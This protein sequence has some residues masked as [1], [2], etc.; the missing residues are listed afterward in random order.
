MGLDPTNCVLK[1]NWVHLRKSGS[2]Q[3]VGNKPATTCQFAPNSI[4]QTTQM[5]KYNT[6]GIA[7]KVGS[8]FT[9][10]VKNAYSLEQ[11]NIAINCTN[12]KETRWFSITTGIIIVGAKNYE[13]SVGTPD[14]VANCGT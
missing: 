4:Y 12:T 7:I 8:P 6:F 1:P 13:T 5:Y 11:K 9:A 10:S 2:Y 3:T 14:F